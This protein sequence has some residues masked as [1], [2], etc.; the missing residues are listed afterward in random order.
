M[1]VSLGFQ[2]FLELGTYLTLKMDSIA[3][4][5]SISH[6]Y[7]HMSTQYFISFSLTNIS[8]LALYLICNLTKYM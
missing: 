5:G 4:D 6:N 7:S 3:C 8:Q 1:F 2:T